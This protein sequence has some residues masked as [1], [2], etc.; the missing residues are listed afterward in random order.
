MSSVGLRTLRFTNEEVLKETEHVLRV[1]RD[2]LRA[3]QP[4]AG[5]QEG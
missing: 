4:R 5:D 3:A 2:Y 1:I